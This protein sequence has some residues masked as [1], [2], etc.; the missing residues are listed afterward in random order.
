MGIIKFFK[1]IIHKKKSLDN[2]DEN[3]H[4]HTLLDNKE[5]QIDNSFLNKNDND[6]LSV[7]HKNTNK[8][9]NEYINEKPK[10]TEESE[11]N[12]QEFDEGDNEWE[13]KYINDDYWRYCM[14]GTIPPLEE[15]FGLHYRHDEI[16]RVPKKDIAELIYQ[17][18][19]EYEDE[20]YIPE[21]WFYYLHNDYFMYDDMNYD[22]D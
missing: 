8:N 21:E 13:D 18:Y 3:C 12:Q 11:I 2:L 15:K 7:N 10:N 4:Q 22:E 20:E 19:I 5:D 16:E 14:F 6:Y 17:G 9:C 1:L